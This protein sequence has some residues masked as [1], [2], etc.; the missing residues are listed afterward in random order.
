V[1]VAQIGLVKLVVTAAVAVDR[2]VMWAHEVQQH[3]QPAPAEGLDFQAASAQITSLLV[4]Q[5]TVAP[6]VVV[7]QVDLVVTDLLQDSARMTELT[8][9]AVRELPAT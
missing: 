6:A 2:Q 8:A 3:N 7:V 9:R 1:A 5:A 4:V